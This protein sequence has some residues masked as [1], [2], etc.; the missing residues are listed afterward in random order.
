L[1]AWSRTPEQREKARARQRRTRA[2]D[3]EATRERQ[4]RYREANRDRIRAIRREKIEWLDS[5][6]RLHGCVDC[7]AREG[8]LH[9]DHRDDEVKLFLPADGRARSWAQLLAEVAKC[10]VRCASCHMK[11]H[12]KAKQEE[13]SR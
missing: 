12:R 13:L 2:A 8:L 6:R 1:R 10:D 5:Y 3:P 4:R 9:L 7:G 11:R